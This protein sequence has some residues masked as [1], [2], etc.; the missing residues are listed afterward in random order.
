[1]DSIQDPCCTSGPHI[2]PQSLRGRLVEILLPSQFTQSLE[3]SL[4]MLLQKFVLKFRRD[5]QGLMLQLHAVTPFRSSAVLIGNEKVRGSG[6]AASPPSHGAA[7]IFPVPVK[8]I[9]PVPAP[10][11]GLQR[12]RIVVPSAAW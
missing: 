1:M 8:A 10:P 5:T 3:V 6:E 7:V 11:C 9:F 2:V 12:N 4:D